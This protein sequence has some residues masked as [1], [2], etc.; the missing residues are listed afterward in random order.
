M[1]LEAGRAVPDIAEGATPQQIAAAQAAARADITFTSTPTITARGLTLRQD[2]SEFAETAPATFQNASGA[3][4]IPVIDF[5]QTGGTQ[6]DRAWA[7]PALRIVETGDVTLTAAGS[8]ANDLGTI[9]SQGLLD[10]GSR[11]IYVETSGN[12]I[13]PAGTTTMLARLRTAGDITLIA[14]NIILPATLTEI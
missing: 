4:L 12:I 3:A 7:S 13:L 5:D 8:G 14:A 1:V 9:D 11:S 2:G 10:L 6:T